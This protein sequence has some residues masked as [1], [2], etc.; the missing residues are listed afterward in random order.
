[1]EWHETPGNVRLAELPTVTLAQVHAFLTEVIDCDLLGGEARQY[2]NV[3]D[4]QREQNGKLVADDPDELYEAASYVPNR[5]ACD[6]P[7]WNRWGMA[8]YAGFGGH[9]YGLLAL[10]EWSRKNPQSAQRDC[11]ARWQAYHGSPPT[12]IGAGSIYRAAQQHGWQRT[13]ANRAK[14]ASAYAAQKQ[15]ERRKLINP[16]PL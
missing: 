10:I 15:Q 16:P 1:M 13:V 11:L 12:A 3:P 8:L 4:Q 7:E 2:H 14:Q 9:D 5:S 6:W